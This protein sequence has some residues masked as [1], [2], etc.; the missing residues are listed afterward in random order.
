MSG[1]TIRQALGH[2]VKSTVEGKALLIF[3]DM[4]F[5]RLNIFYEKRLYS[6]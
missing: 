1:K 2:T 3:T 6:K 5:D 4:D